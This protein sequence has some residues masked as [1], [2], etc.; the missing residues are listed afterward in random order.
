MSTV[1]LSGARWRKSSFSS[2]GGDNEN[3]VEV[4][5]VG[6]AA[7]LRDSKNTGGPALVVATAS[8]CALLTT[9]KSA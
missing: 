3:C 4:A 8:W 9:T 5:L 6:P 1:D 2:G 7:A